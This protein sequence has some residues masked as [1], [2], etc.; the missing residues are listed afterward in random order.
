VPGPEVSDADVDILRYVRLHP[1]PFASA[2]DMEPKTNVGYRQTRNRMD[3]LVEK[4]LLN[5]RKVG[6]VKLYWL[7]GSGKR[8]LADVDEP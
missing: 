7:T 1:E 3:Q 8:A 5:V 4:G 2:R 6:T